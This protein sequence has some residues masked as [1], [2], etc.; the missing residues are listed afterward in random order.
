[1]EF[2]GG[3]LFL[4]TKILVLATN[5]LSTFYDTKI[6]VLATNFFVATK[7]LIQFWAP[8][9]LIATKIFRYY[10]EHFLKYY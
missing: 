9:N 3:K 8:K 10:P 4:A 2:N 5:F 6:L 1:M 7:I